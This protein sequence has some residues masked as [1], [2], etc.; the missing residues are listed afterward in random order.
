[1]PSKTQE[2][3]L[4]QDEISGTVESVIYRQEESGYTVCTVRIPA[5]KDTITVVGKC[6]AIWV[7]ETIRSEGVWTRHKSHGYQFQA[8]EMRCIAPTSTT[9]IQRYLASGMIRGIGKVMAK[10]MV[11]KF[12]DD[13]LKIIESESARLEEVEG[14]GP[15]RRQMIKES[16]IENRAIRDIMIFLQSHGVGVG[17]SARIY[18][19]YGSQAIAIISDNPYRLC[20]DV[21]GIGFKTADGVAQSLGIP[22]ESEVRA[23]AGLVYVLQVANDDGHCHTPNAELILQAQDLL[24]IP[25]ERLK[26]ALAHELKRG[27]LILEDNRVY[28]KALFDDECETADRITRMLHCDPSFTPIQ[29]DKAIPW[30][31]K[32]MGIHFADLQT[33]ALHSALSSKVSIITGGPG[34]GKTTIIRALVDVYFKRDLKI[35]LAAPTGRAAKRMQEATHRPAMTLHRLLKFNPHGGGFEHDA[36]NPLD[37]DVAIIDEVSMMDL[38]LMSSFLCAL[39]PDTTLIL[40][41]DTDQLPSVGPGNVLRDLIQSEQIPCKRLNQIFRQSHAGLIVQNA[42]RVNQG[43]FIEYPRSGAGIDSDFYFID[44][45]EPEQVIEQLVTLVTKR[46]PKKFGLDP[47]TD[48]QVL[49]PMRRN[50]L[51]AENL[52]AV[53][54]EALNPTGDQVQKFGR[55]YRLNDRVMQI[56][57]NYDKE[58]FNGDIGQITDVDMDEHAIVVDFDGRKITYEVSELDELMHAYACS[59]HKSQGSEYPAVVILITT[60]HFKMLQ[61]NLLY[62]AITRGKKL[63]CLIGST[64]AVGMA[65]NNNTIRLRRTSLR[66]RVIAAVDAQIALESGN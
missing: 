55:F 47:M 37:T 22:L 63:V 27:T 62:T 6:G 29:V 34:V 41:G 18:R 54:Q 61:R 7:G 23:R 57:N 2:P 15:T 4:Q 12:G 36:D 33:E 32:R 28:L 9:G 26:D 42:H 39:R 58:V 25:A 48:V 40:V 31:E 60:Q 13:T 17:Q 21:W 44:S 51:G 53:L 8:K 11:A 64:K 19:R 65:I 16:W 35:S 20:T 1:M 38:P 30:A 59:I 52:N 50:Q 43:E 66:L 24:G 5:R 45:S 49:S 14:I 3:D 46:I 56:R 10:R